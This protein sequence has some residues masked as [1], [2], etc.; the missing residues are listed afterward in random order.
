[1]K[2]QLLTS[3]LL[4]VFL[5]LILF[6]CRSTSL[7][8]CT[9]NT[10]LENYVKMN[11]TSYEGITRA[12]LI[13]YGLDTQMMI[14]DNISKENKRQIFL[15]Y[16]D[17]LKK[18]NSFSV[19]ELSHISLLEQYP[20][21]KL[22]SQSQ[23]SRAWLDSWRE[24]GI[25]QFGWTD[26]QIYEYFEVHMFK[27]EIKNANFP[28]GFNPDCNCKYSIGCKY[29]SGERCVKGNCGESKTNCGIMY[30]EVCDGLCK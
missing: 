5:P 25:A 3:I 19:S 22:Y 17:T 18:V 8:D 11:A 10:E 30:N 4:A 14:L 16:F 26:E 29:F 13:E 24:T 15:E 1:M 23:E 9:P 27:V 20:S 12:E 7:E 28:Y 6:S 2:N 21:E